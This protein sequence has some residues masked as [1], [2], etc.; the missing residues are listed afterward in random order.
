MESRNGTRLLRLGDVSKLT[1]LG[2]TT[3]KLWVVQNKF[4]P[5]TTLSKTITVWSQ[6]DVE[7]WIETVLDKKAETTT[8]ATDPVETDR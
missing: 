7:D 2:K 1:S 6:R 5:P 3:I 8:E 4:P